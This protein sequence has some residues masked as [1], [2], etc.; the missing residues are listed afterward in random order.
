MS[1]NDIPL[2]VV[3]QPTGMAQAVLTEVSLHLHALAS[4]GSRHAIDLR[5]LPMNDADRAELAN[6]LG[7]GEVRIEIANIG[8]SLIAETGYAGVWWVTH[9]DPKGE[10]TAELIEITPIPDIA[11]THGDD[12]AAAADRMSALVSQP[13]EETHTDG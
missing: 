5:S 1:L 7:Q 12:I 10:V 13:S 6:H 8:T 4:D 11:V 9:K 2:A 3:E